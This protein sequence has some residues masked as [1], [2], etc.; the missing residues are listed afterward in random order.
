[1]TE[2][3]APTVFIFKALY[4][5]K[6]NS[7]SLYPQAKVFVEKHAFKEVLEVNGLRC[8]IDVRRRSPWGEGLF[9][10]AKLEEGSI[11]NEELEIAF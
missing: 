4:S 9:P 8:L 7:L 11:E 10:R 1:M 6:Y 2:N 5:S 3:R